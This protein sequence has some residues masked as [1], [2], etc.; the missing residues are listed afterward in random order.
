M[1]GPGKHRIALLLLSSDDETTRLLANALAEMADLTTAWT[2]K[3]FF[4]FLKSS[5]YDLA[6]CDWDC[7]GADWRQ[8]CRQ[9]QRDHPDLPII[10]VSR[11]GGEQEWVEVLKEGCFDLIT[12][13]YSD[14]YVLSVIE[15]A[16]ASREAHAQKSA[17]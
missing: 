13:P 12:A 8:V 3:D 4:E 17:A 5:E 2:V 7:Q 11:C 9:V 6:L 10:V 1:W 16:V 14:R 15:H